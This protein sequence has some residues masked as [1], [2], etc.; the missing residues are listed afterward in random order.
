MDTNKM[1]ALAAKLGDNG[2]TA[3]GYCLIAPMRFATAKEAK[4]Y[5]ADN[6]LLPD[7]KLSWFNG[8]EYEIL[9]D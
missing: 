5:R 8:K 1:L 9:E 7:W 6:D 2:H 3:T 4:K